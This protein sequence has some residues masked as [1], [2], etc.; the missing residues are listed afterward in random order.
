MT[1][2]NSKSKLNEEFK[3]LSNSIEWWDE[4][5]E[6]AANEFDEIMHQIDVIESKTEY[7]VEDESILETLIGKLAISCH[8][9]ELLRAR[10]NFEIKNLDGLE[11]R[12]LE[13]NKNKKLKNGK[14]KT[15]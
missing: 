6:R 15:E 13:A 9:L 7:C 8:Q 11:K 2:Q 12:V 1:H 10:G 14:K 5:V 3:H 4:Q